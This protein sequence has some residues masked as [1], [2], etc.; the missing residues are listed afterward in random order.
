MRGNPLPGRSPTSHTTSGYLVRILMV[1]SGV[2]AVLLVAEMR[3]LPPALVGLLVPY[4]A[5]VSWHLLA[6]TRPRPS[7]PHPLPPD[8]KAVPRACISPEVGG[9]ASPGGPGERVGPS[10]PRGPNP[11]PADPP[12]EPRRSRARRR[13]KPVSPAMPVPIPWV[14]VGPG[15]YVRGEAPDPAPDRPA[16]PP[17]VDMT[18]PVPVEVGQPSETVPEERSRVPEAGDSPGDPG[19]S[20][21]V[22]EGDRAGTVEDPIAPSHESDVVPHREGQ[23]G[24]EPEVGEITGWHWRRN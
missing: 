7:K 8:Q 15:R 5:L 9:D 20:E 10:D 6:L 12:A 21:E 23:I 17:V 16:E 24:D 4:L 11:D 14:Q 19:G 13:P 1:W 18:E 3:S 2:L 22:G